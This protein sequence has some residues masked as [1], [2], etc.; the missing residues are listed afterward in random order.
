MQEL[1]L[2][3]EYFAVINSEMLVKIVL[4][5]KGNIKLD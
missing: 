5:I 3:N 4:G 2:S 1:S